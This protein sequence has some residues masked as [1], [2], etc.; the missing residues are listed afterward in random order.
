MLSNHKGRLFFISILL[1]IFSKSALLTAQVNNRWPSLANTPW[2]MIH[3]NPQ[4]NGR[5]E[6]KGPQSGNILWTL[7]LPYGILSGPIIGPDRTLYCGSNNNRGIDEFYAINPDGTVKWKIIT[8]TSGIFGTAPNSALLIDSEGIIYFG[9]ANGKFYAV[10][11]EGNIKWIYDVGSATYQQ[12]LVNDLEG[13]LYIT[14][15]DGFLHAV[16]KDGIIKWKKFYGTGFA[17]R[18]PAIS[19]DG[20]HIY[21]CGEYENLYCI[22]TEGELL[23][24]YLCGKNMSPP[25]IDENGNIII[26]PNDNNTRI[27]SV[28]SEGIKKWENYIYHRNL[29]IRSAPTIDNNGNIYFFSYDSLSSQFCITS[30]D[31]D[32]NFRWNFLLAKDDIWQPLICDKEGTIYFGSTKGDYYYSVSSEGILKWKIPLNS[33]QVDNTSAIDSNGVLFIGVHLTSVELGQEKTLI[34]I[35]DSIN[36]GMISSLNEVDFTTSQNYP[37]PFN[38]ST[39]IRYSLPTDGIVT[40][41]VFDILGREV[42]TLAGEYKNAGSY[43]VIWDSKDSF[44]SEVSSGIYF[45]NIKFGDNS[46]TKKMILVR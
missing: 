6:F 27:I 18:S 1:I 26:I 31:N 36:T 33:Y 17:N 39:A 37:N 41:R 46:I 19:K 35:G 10:D 2:P 30:V 16:K 20:K 25:V 15:S 11:E 24:Q 9:A 21:I 28:N 13:T 4:S 3:N 40:I 44:G 5:S 23:W 14:S 22:S 34:A 42:R 38:P 43:N 29:D 7:D 12:I 45:Y 8:D 32:G